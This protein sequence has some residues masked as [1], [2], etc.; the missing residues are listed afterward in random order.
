MVVEHVR[1]WRKE[2]KVQFEGVV[3]TFGGEMVGRF[4]EELRKF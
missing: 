4:F 3:G 1:K 2:I